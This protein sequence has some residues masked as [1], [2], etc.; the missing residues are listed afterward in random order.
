MTPRLLQLIAVRAQIDAMIAAEQSEPVPAPAI[1]DCLPGEN[2]HECE[3][4]LYDKKGQ[5]PHPEERR[6]VSNNM[7]EEPQFW[8]PECKSFVKGVA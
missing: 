1:C 7:G 3:G 4:T 6:I 5:C 8:C 2:C